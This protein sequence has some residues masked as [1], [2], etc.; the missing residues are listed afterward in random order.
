VKSFLTLARQHPPERHEVHLNDTLK[1]AMELM[2][3]P[4]RVDGVEVHI[5]LAEELPPIWADPHQIHQ[6]VVHLVSNAH[7]ALLE[8]ARPRQLTVSTCYD[9]P[10][11]RVYLGVADTGPGIPAELQGRIF[12]PFFTTKAPRQ[13]MGL[14]LPLCLG[15]IEAHGGAIRLES[16]PGEGTLFVIELPIAARPTSIEEARPDDIPA[17]PQAGAI[18]VVDDEPEVANVLAEL[19]MID[20]HQ[21]DTA[22]NGAVAL[23]KLQGRAYDL[24]LSD[25][26]MPEMDGPGLYQTLERHHPAL[27]RRMIFMTGDALTPETQGFLAGTVVPSVSKPFSLQEIR[28]LIQQLLQASI[29]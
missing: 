16:R 21:V 14:G 23:R 15:I 4:L 20:G 22:P 28:H 13:G 10:R 27:A 7:Q 26:R 11:S 17:P 12:E 2:A 25:L 6:V 8:S 3:Y 19:L 9:L 1:E 5:N 24:I 18:L 29:T